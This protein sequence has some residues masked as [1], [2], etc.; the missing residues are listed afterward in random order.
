MKTE[1]MEIIDDNTKR[2][3]VEFLVTVAKRYFSHQWHKCNKDR[4]A[5]MVYNMVTLKCIVEKQFLSFQP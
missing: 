1:C 3:Q 4:R 5:Y 2:I